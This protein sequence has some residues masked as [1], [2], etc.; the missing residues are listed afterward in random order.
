VLIAVVL[1][2]WWLYISRSA[3]EPAA[4]RVA[5]GSPAV[6]ISDSA[7][8]ARNGSAPAA[9]RET[10][11]G[12][13]TPA[14]ADTALVH[15]RYRVVG[16]DRAGAEKRVAGEE[17]AAGEDDASG[18][19]RAALDNRSE[20]KQQG[21]LSGDGAAAASDTTAVPGRSA[22]PDGAQA[23]EVRASPGATRAPDLSPDLSLR[24]ARGAETARA[25][26]LSDS[27]IVVESLGQFAG[28]Y[29]IHVSSFQSV[30]RTE[31]ESFYLLG[32]GYPV[33]IYHVDLGGKGKWF[34]VCVGPYATQA[35]AQ[36]AKIKLDG[37]PR[38]LSTRLSKVPG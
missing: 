36:A 23:R 6:S 25:L 18:E 33:F 2:I 20:G 28:Q 17:H 9:A 34:R 14:A 26:G 3:R 13:R 32:W 12:S 1:V 24:S 21:Q 11:G 15:P 30:R 22:A 38:I 10:S 4:G 7:L 5:P 19:H 29:M 31:D 37:N 27:L 35:E 8:A 16:E